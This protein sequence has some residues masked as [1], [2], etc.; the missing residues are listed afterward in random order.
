M[1]LKIFVTFI[2][3][4]LLWKAFCIYQGYRQYLDYKRQGV[5]FLSGG[6]SLLGDMGKLIGIAKKYPSAFSWLR[7]FKE[8]MDMTEF[9]PVIGITPLGNCSIMVT[10]SDMLQDLYVNKNALI[11]KD[12]IVRWQFW[13]LMSSSIVFQDT[14]DPT[15]VEKRKSLSQA[16]FKSKLV[17]MTTIIKEVTLKEIKRVQALPSLDDVSLAHLTLKLQS[18]IIINVSVGKNYSDK[19]FEYE[20]A[21]GSLVK[22][23]LSDYLDKLIVDTISRLF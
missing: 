21:S 17:G 11:T 6:F 2:V 18:R 7:I 5:V 8:S 13:K 9:P 15:Y 19:L 16:F 4:Y 10:S 1:L 14:S 12:F 22:V 3:G 20:E 23:D